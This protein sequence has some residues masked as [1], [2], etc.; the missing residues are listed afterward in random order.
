MTSLEV[1][2]KE[3]AAKSSSENDWVKSQNN[4][5]NTKNKKREYWSGWNLQDWS[6]GIIATT[7][8]MTSI[9][10]GRRNVSE[11]RLR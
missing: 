1:A 10:L 8:K 6:S 2:I 9:L 3:Q 4:L 5:R 11:K 7:N